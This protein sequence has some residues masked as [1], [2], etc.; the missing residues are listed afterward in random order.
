MQRRTKRRL[1]WFLLA[2]VCVALVAWLYE[3]S[4]GFP[5]FVEGSWVYRHTEWVG[6]EWSWPLGLPPRRSE[7]YYYYRDARGNLVAYS[8]CTDGVFSHSARDHA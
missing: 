8:R 7:V 2:A 6:S 1:I 3:V 5:R 4:V